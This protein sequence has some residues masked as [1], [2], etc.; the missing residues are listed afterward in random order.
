MKDFNQEKIL[1]RNSLLKNS[2]IT[3]SPEIISYYVG[4]ILKRTSFYNNYKWLYS[5]NYEFHKKFTIQ[6]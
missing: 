4:V 3:K 2:K 1:N 5:N 6:K